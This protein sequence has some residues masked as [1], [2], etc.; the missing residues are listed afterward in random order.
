[1]DVLP[2]GLKDALLL[3]PKVFGDQRGF[4]ME[5]YQQERYKD[6]GIEFRFVQDNISK[7][8]YGTLRGL[9]FQ[10]PP[11]DQGKLVFVLEGTVLDVIV[12]IRK[13]S[14]TFGQSFQ[15]ELSAENKKQLWVPP[16][17][18]HGFVVLSQ[19]AI[20]AYK[21]TNF[22]NQRAEGGV[23][24]SDEFLNIDWQVKQPILSEKDKKL[25]LWDDFQSPF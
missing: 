14:L 24:W 3:T 17:F 19:S 11:Y 16:G 9:H 5:T 15:V 13:K 10:A 8:S 22:Y 6:A 7:S 21:C 1:M 18:A 2:I 20:F 25:S 12:D 4:F 23:L